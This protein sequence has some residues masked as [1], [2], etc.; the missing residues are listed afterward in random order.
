MPND[1]MVDGLAGLAVPEDRGFPLVGDADGGDFG[2]LYPR[3]FQGLLACFL[4]RAPYLVGVV[5][6]PTWLGKILGE[7]LVSASHHLAGVVE[8]IGSGAGG[9]LV[10]G[11]D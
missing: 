1:G 4:D 2:G 3:R 11:E 5:F 9:A 6:D 8:K 7:F 10:D